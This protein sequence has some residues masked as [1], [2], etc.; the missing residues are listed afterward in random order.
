VITVND[1]RITTV[2]DLIAALSRYDTATPVRVAQRFRLHIGPQNLHCVQHNVEQV[3]RASHNADGTP[4]T[5]APVWLS[6]GDQVGQ[7]PTP[8]ADA[9]GWS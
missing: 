8:A 7:L 6:I 2:G 1:N 5:D 4:A 9:L 3:A